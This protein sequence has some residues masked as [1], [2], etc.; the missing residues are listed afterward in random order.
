MIA[1]TV[2]GGASR[3]ARPASTLSDQADRGSKSCDNK[4]EVRRLARRAHIVAIAREHFFQHGFAGTT[5]SAI[6]LT[7]GGSKATLWSYFASKEA[8]LEAVVRDTTEVVQRDTILSL[9]TDGDPADR[10]T[11]LC[12]SMI[13][14]ACSPIV[15]KLIRLIGPLADQQPEIAKIFFECGPGETLDLI[16]EYLRNQFPDSVWTADYPAAARDLL[17]L[18]ITE[19]QLQRAWGVG[20]K[21]TAADKEK[22]ARHAAAVFLRAYGKDAVSIPHDTA[23][24]N[25][26]MQS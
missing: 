10:L 24:A 18:S 4:R 19:I 20:H 9:P 22:R 14:R 2:S 21:M 17:G 11:E 16:G 7:L 1:P 25:P 6:A 15:T 3:Q 13:E 26:S 12:R 8:L 5:M 23:C